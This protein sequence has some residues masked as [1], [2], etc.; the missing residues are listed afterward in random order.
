MRIWALWA[1]LAA[2]GCAR[3][4]YLRPSP[5]IT[6]SSP[7]VV[8]RG[9]LAVAQLR[10]PLSESTSHSGDRFTLEL[11]DPLVDGQGREQ[12][13]RGAVIEG[14]LV[15]AGAQ[16]QG[17]RWALEVL[18]VRSERGLVSLPAEVGS[19]PFVHEGGWGMAVV[20]GFAGAAAGTG[21]GLAI[22]ADQASVVVGAAFIGAGIGALVGW[23]VGRGEAVLPS[24][25]VVT[26]RLVEDSG[27]AG[28]PDAE[29]P[30]AR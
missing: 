19:A 18:G 1:L 5:P 27:P 6:R 21:A 7:D 10:Q 15:R 13:S 17:G 20:G 26:L 24:G 3:E 29:D 12:V 9:T 14:R 22:D 25:S 28:L 11:L 4:T 16:A 30:E 2:G 8:P 23:L